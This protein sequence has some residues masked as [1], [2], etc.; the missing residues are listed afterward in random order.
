MSIG[1][2]LIGKGIITA[3]AGVGIVL[4]VVGIATVIIASIIELLYLWKTKSEE[5]CNMILKND[6]KKG[7]IWSGAWVHSS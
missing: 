3:P 2:A 4:I 5:F 6:L 1:G 7:G